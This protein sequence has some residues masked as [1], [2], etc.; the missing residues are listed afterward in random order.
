MSQ[1]R[2]APEITAH[3]RAANIYAIGNWAVAEIKRLGAD[4]EGNVLAS[5]ELCDLADWC[6]AWIENDPKDNGGDAS[7]RRGMRPYWPRIYR[8]YLDLRG[9]A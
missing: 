8:A 5:E 4:A 1:A 3:Y 2:S 7:V 6:W 9:S